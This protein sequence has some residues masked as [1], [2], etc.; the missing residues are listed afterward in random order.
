MNLTR[1]PLSWFMVIYFYFLASTSAFTKSDAFRYF[2]MHSGIPE[3]LFENDPVQTLVSILFKV[4][5]RF[6]FVVGILT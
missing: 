1:V 4:G 5:F 2:S 3:L 6:N